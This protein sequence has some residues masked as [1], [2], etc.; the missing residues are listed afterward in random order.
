M[1]DRHRTDRHRG[2]Y[3]KYFVVSPTKRGPHGEASRRAVREYAEA[4]KGT[5]PAMAQDLL[6]WMAEVGADDASRE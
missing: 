3:M 4:I 1:A 5:D 2:L 6:A